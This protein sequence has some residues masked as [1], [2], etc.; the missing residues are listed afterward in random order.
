MKKQRISA[1]GRLLFTVLGLLFYPAL[2]FALA[3]KLAAGGTVEPGDPGVTL[4]V[5]LL[6][7]G[8]LAIALTAWLGWRRH[9]RLQDEQQELEERQ[10]KGS[11]RT[12]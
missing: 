4:F 5:V 8:E 10:R 11:G 7:A 3:S 12:R 6:A 2:L 1:R 9:R